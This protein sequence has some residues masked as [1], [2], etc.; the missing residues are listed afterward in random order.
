MYWTIIYSLLPLSFFPPSPP[1]LLSPLLPSLPQ[2]LGIALIGVG[3]Y[4]IHSGNSLSTFTGNH[5]FSGAA[6]LILCGIVVFI[7]TAVGIAAAFFQLKFVLYLVSE[8]V[9][10]RE[11]GMKSG[12]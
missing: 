4:L 8:W 11:G 2:L 1:S 7:I 12:I 3:S 9:C 5:F 6:I 10:W